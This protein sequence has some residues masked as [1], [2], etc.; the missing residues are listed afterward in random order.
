LAEALNTMAK[1][2]SK[3]MSQK[4]SIKLLTLSCFLVT[5]GE[6][7]I[8]HGQDKNRDFSQLAGTIPHEIPAK[9]SVIVV[10]CSGQQTLD[11]DLPDGG[12]LPQPGVLNLQ[13]L[14]T[15]RDA[16]QVADGDGWTYAH[17][18]DLAEW[19]GRLYAAWNMTLKD[20]DVPPSKVVFASS[21]NGIEWSKPADLFPREM[22]WACRFYFYHS[23]NDRMLAFCA[24][25]V[26]DGNVSEDLKSVLLVREIKPDHSLGPVFTLIHPVEKMPAYFETSSDR[27]FVEA[28]SEAAMNNM[29]LEQQDYGMFL[30]DRKMVWHSK[31]PPYKGFFKFGKAFS[32]Y[33]RQDGQWV[34]IS[35]MGFVTHS[36]DEGKSWSEPVIPSSLIAGSAKIWGQRTSDNRYVLAYNPDPKREKR[37]PLVVVSGEDGIHYRDMRV[38][39]GEFPPLRYPGRY[40]D[41]GYQYVRGVAAWAS[42]HSFKDK[43]SVWMIYSVHKEDIWLSR[44][45]LP[46]LSKPGTSITD[47][48]QNTPTV[49]I[50]PNWNIYSPKWAP[51]R[52]VDEPG[53][54]QNRC[55]ELKDGDPV[56]YARAMCLFQAGNPVEIQFRIKPSQL[57]A[58]MEVDLQDEKGTSWL[59]IIF[60]KKGVLK[61]T[62]SHQD[63]VLGK[64]FP[65][66]WNSI[67]LTADGKKEITDISFDGKT[68]HLAE[69]VKKEDVKLQRLVFRTGPS[70]KLGDTDHVI[71]GKDQPLKNPAVFLVDDVSVKTN[72]L[73]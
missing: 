25:R 56:D 45:P 22:A 26:S 64:Y 30:G 1:K 63:V 39:H 8:L 47:D 65:E 43:E 11:L 42:D 52:I 49:A 28:C 33:Q 54:P 50:L 68:F 37:F 27:P 62:S 6:I 72:N 2:I 73:F 57:T 7:S 3:Q 29:L 61:A 12:L 70:R 66:K 38:I 67:K 10:T 24:A 17:H 23:Q 44:I 35:K 34:G 20:E 48:F 59:K 18:M 46:V 32:F 40:K 16:P 55:L 36:P 14:R 9:D 13:L 71:A 69:G 58:L 19:R 53:T 41:F 5:M 60:T 15:T 51:V 31:T 21:E 4:M